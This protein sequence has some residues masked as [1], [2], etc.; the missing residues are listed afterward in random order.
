[1][2]S[3]LTVVLGLLVTAASLLSVAAHATISLLTWFPIENMKL[4][5]DDASYIYGIYGLTAAAVALAA[6]AGL[7]RLPGLPVVLVAGSFSLGLRTLLPVLVAQSVSPL[8]LI[9]LLCVFMGTS[10]ALTLAPISLS[11][12]RIVYAEYSCDEDLRAKRFN[13][14][15]FLLYAISNAT[16]AL[17]NVGYGAMRESPLLN[18]VTSNVAM[19]AF[20]VTAIAL[21]LVLVSIA[22][23]KVGYADQSMADITKRQWDLTFRDARFWSFMAMCTVLLLVRMLFR[24]L[25]FT[26]PLFL[27][28]ALDINARFGYMQ[29]INPVVVFFFVPAFAL[30]GPW[31]GQYRVFREIT[32]YWVI[33]LGTLLSS[34]GFFLLAGLLSAGV[35]VYTASALGIV[36]FSLGE[37]IWSPLFTAYAMRIAPEGSEAVY[38]ALVSVPG[39]VAKFPTAAL[40][41]ALVSQYCPAQGQCQGAL[42]WASIAGIAAL[43]PFLMTLGYRC[44]DA[45]REEK[46]ETREC[47]RRCFFVNMCCSRMCRCCRRVY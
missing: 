37:S 20:G 31:L 29:A 26:L 25:D 10:D 45:S 12:K 44:L 22:M 5:S 35:E 43:S 32:S 19:I 8:V 39:L 16:A 41:N 18:H 23:F 42:L 3:Q 21:A 6:S 4:T 11:I 34:M 2:S 38:T 14:I 33:V 40:S 28:R 17:V 13:Q 46:E 1:M 27:T 47:Q 15:I 7:D 24:H 36:L 9:L 30:I